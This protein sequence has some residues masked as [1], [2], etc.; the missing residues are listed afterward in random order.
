MQTAARFA[1]AQN[2]GD[3]YPIRVPLAPFN[4]CGRAIGHEHEGQPKDVTRILWCSH[5]N[6]PYERKL[7]YIPHTR[8]NPKRTPLKPPEPRT[9]P[10]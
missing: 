9:T 3:R 8:F 5:D 10:R 2:R 1:D 4:R 6:L 7:S